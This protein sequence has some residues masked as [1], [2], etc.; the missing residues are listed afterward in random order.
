[1]VVAL[2]PLLDNSNIFDIVVLTSINS[3]FIQFEIFLVPDINNDFFKL[4]Y[5]GYYKTLDLL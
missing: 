5:F 4:K 3:L 2:K 1:M